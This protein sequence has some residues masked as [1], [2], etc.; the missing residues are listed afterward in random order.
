[1]GDRYQS[2]ERFWPYYL[3]EHRDRGCRALHYLGTSSAI[4]S[5]VYGIVMLEPGWLLVAPF[6]GYGAAWAG[7][8]LVEGNRP[9]TFS[10]PL[11]SLR[12]DLRMLRLALTGT[13]RR[14]RAFHVV[15][16]EGRD[17]APPR[18]SPSP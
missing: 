1:M 9:A 6:L 5:A 16:F 7:H 10:Y 4:G 14:D 13:L 18:R 8:F 3:S 2:F 17:P 11:W 12:G 15:V